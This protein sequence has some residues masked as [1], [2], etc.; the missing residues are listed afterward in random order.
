MSRADKLKQTNEIT[1]RTF[2]Y[3]CAKYECDK[4]DIK[5]CVEKFIPARTEFIERCHYLGVPVASIGQMLGDRTSECIQSY[6]DGNGGSIQTP[7]KKGGGVCNE[8]L[9]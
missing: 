2:N 3:T 5:G 8:N 9:Q 7:I 6:L 4:E 1:R